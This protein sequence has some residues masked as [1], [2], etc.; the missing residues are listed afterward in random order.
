MDSFHKGF[1]GFVCCDLD[2]KEEFVKENNGGRLTVTEE[3]IDLSSRPYF[4]DSVSYVFLND[5]YGDNSELQNH[6]DK[7]PLINDSRLRKR[8]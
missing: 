2:G 4:S 3:Y 7:Y 6:N 8:L 1:I 5:D